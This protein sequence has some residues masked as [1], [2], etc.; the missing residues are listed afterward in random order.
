[1]SNLPFEFID[2][3]LYPEAGGKD[4]QLNSL[5]RDH[6][7]GGEEGMA[8][9]LKLLLSMV[10]ERARAGDPEGGDR[11]AEDDVSPVLVTMGGL[12]DVSYNSDEVFRK[13]LEPG[14]GIEK[15]VRVARQV[16][17]SRVVGSCAS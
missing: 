15:Y 1:M 7:T 11:K 4:R 8:T 17:F 13:S 5:A 12:H 14:R 10:L 6:E 16:G 9:R 2:L 3:R